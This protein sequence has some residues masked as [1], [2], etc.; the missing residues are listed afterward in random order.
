[1]T[2]DPDR[3]PLDAAAL[4]EVL[5]RHR[6]AYVVVGGYAAEL[7][8][9]VRRTVDV[10]VVPRTT[11]DNLERLTQALRELRARIRTDDDSA[12][13]PFAT[14]AEVLAGMS[15]LNLVTAHGELDLNFTPTG[16]AGYEDLHTDATTFIVGRV[17][18]QV[19]S[20]AAVI[21]SKTAAGRGKDLDALPELHRLAGISK[22]AKDAVDTPPRSAR[23]LAQAGYPEPVQP[24]T[25]AELAQARIDAARRHAGGTRADRQQPPTQR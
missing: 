8:G 24:V 10:D 21:R 7:H 17:Q 20:L 12:G 2:D 4:F 16:T 25:A 15:M 11:L 1:V 19:A 3:V 13:L 5:E 9:S 22:T 18:V 23:E 6:V 14:S